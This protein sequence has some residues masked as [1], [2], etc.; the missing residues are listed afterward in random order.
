M[1]IYYTIPLLCA[2]VYC[3]GTFFIKR[4]T[5]YGVGAMRILFLSNWTLFIF[6]LPSL[7]KNPEV[8]DWALLWVP[9]VTS[10]CEFSAGILLMLSIRMGNLSIQIP[11]MGTKVVF[12]AMFSMLIFGYPV[13]LGWWIGVC[14]TV[15]AIFLVG[16][17]KF[18][19]TRTT[20]LSML[21]TI[22]SMIIYALRDL[23]IVDKAA[24]FGH[25]AFFPLTFGITAILSLFLIPLFR[26]QLWSTPARAWKWSLVGVALLGLQQ[27]AFM[28]I[29]AQFDDVTPINIVYSSRGVWSVVIA[30]VIAHFFKG[31]EIH[32]PRPVFVRRFIGSVLMCVAIVIVLVE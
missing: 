29:L 13:P 18:K 31:Q 24:A 23:V 32:T 16:F 15:L 21:L 3:F 25:D 20:Y 28:S 30:W 5:S 10:L 19:Q 9:V 7:V 27:Y 2:I 26:K 11:L 1:P 6:S 22:S 14:V 17:S 12:V 8:L 4:A